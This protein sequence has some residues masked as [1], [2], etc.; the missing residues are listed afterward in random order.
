MAL[1]AAVLLSASA[2]FADDA[3]DIIQRYGPPDKDDSTAYDQ[4]R[5]PVVSRFLDY[6]RKNVRAIL[7]PTNPVGAPPPYNWKLLGFFDMAR[8][9]KLS[10]DEA[11]R[12]LGS[13]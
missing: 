9:Q 6:T 5:P 12:R 11:A 2:A 1:A 10:P 7:I 8:Q 3:A 13:R 4:P